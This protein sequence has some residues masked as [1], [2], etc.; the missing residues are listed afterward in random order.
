[1]TKP[2]NLYLL[3]RIPDREAF[4][5]V[6]HHAGGMPPGKMTPV[7]EMESLRIFTNRMIETDVPVSA[8]DG[9]VFGYS[10]PRIGKEFDLLKFG[11]DGCLN[12]E[13]K[14]MPVPLEQMRTQLLKNRHYL[15]HLGMVTELYTFVSDTQQCFHLTE[16]DQLQ[17]VSHTDLAKAVLS[18]SG[19]YQTDID[20]LFRPSEYIVSPLN[21]PEKFL[22]R[23]YFLTQAQEQVRTGLLNAVG[24]TTGTAFFSMTGK[25]GTGKTLL[26]YDV[27]RTL[28]RQA[29]VA[30]L[31]WC[32]DALPES[33]QLICDADAHLD[34]LPWSVMGGGGDAAGSCSTAV[35]G[36]G[37]DA[38]GNCSTAAPGS[39]GDVAATNP[40]GGSGSDADAG[41]A[42]NSCNAATLD[43]AGDAASSEQSGG[44]ILPALAPYTYVLV[45]ET[46]RLTPQ[47]L[48]SICRTA[49]KHHQ[50]VIFSMDPEQ[51]LTSQE[52]VN[53][54]AGLIEALPP[55]AAFTL[56]ERLRGN[57]DLQSFIR[58]VYNLRDKPAA[59]MNYK[60][61][62]LC[63]ANTIAEA[64][65]L[66]EY[67][68]SQD[69]IF[70]N[71]LKTA[72]PHPEEDPPASDTSDS[73][74]ASNPFIEYEG[75]Y[76][77]HH[78]IGQEYDRVVMLLDDSFRYSEDGKLEGVPRPDPD[79]L[80][81][82]LFYQGITRVQEKLSL[83]ILENE[84]LF[85]TISRLLE[86]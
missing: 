35:P 34:I 4:N 6:Y 50:R 31:H 79:Y 59:R 80:Y 67:Y 60:D 8:L 19:D 75:G 44:H 39:A 73:L 17:P 20:G 36:S 68:R 83:I 41:D 66:L 86:P 57:P 69:Y 18:V 10:I 64:Q 74:F 28:S 81:P 12:I 56:S 62:D 33:L 55:A 72:H 40:K 21:T 84:P 61:V 78:V 82:N 47:Q 54:I 46:H 13:L 15:A 70:I 9:F 76:D 63:Y 11:N 7:H 3:S 25:P 48:S 53:N 71:Y 1:M 29:S 51:I 5:N 77:I 85:T 14:S 58:L 22:M 30:I 32:E 65:N 49:E 43:A 24:E 26:L 37:G 45:D 23:E 42:V 27:G 2:L 16:D 52:R 38:I